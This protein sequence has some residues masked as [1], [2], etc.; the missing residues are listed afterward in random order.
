MRKATETKLDAWMSK[1]HQL[2]VYKSFGEFVASEA[3]CIGDARGRTLEEAVS[4]FLEK[5]I[6]KVDGVWHVR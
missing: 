5:R 4:K 1:G 6:T 2:Q 3:G